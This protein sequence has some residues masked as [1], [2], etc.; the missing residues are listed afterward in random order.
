MRAVFVIIGQILNTKPAEMALVERNDV[1]EH[2]ATNTA[3]PS[4]CNS[5]LPR[6]PYACPHR[7]DAACPQEFEDVMAELGV[8]IEQDITIGAG[9]RQCLP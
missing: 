2:L 4:F 7:L 3:H 8:M 1:V 5:V 6:T 9:K